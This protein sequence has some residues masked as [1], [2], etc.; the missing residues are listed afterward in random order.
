MFVTLITS[1]SFRGLGPTYC[2]AYYSTLQPGPKSL[3]MLVVI[4]IKI[5]FYFFKRWTNV[6]RSSPT[7]LAPHVH[8]KVA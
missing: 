7:H 4:E 1:D 8:G 6:S 5:N 3:D 2:A